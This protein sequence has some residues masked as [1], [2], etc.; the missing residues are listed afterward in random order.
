MLWGQGAP[1]HPFA[2]GISLVGE[3]SVFSLLSKARATWSFVP[4]GDAQIP[5]PLCLQLCSL[6]STPKPGPQQGHG[7]GSGDTGRGDSGGA[8]SLAAGTWEPWI[9]SEICIMWETPGGKRDFSAGGTSWPFHLQQLGPCMGC[10]VTPLQ[11][12]STPAPLGLGNPT[13]KG[14]ARTNGRGNAPHPPTPPGVRNPMAVGLVARG[15]CARAAADGGVARGRVSQCPS[16]VPTT[17]CHTAAA[18]LSEPQAQNCPGGFCPLCPPA[19]P[20][21]PALLVLSCPGG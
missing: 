5:S 14:F 9:C 19:V 4:V 1:K 3:K 16:C 12:R 20:H 13:P 21:P 15:G 8:M 10:G 11:G 2:M 17:S 18:A 7:A 6:S